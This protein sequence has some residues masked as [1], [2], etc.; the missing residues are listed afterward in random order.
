MIFSTTFDRDWET[1]T[2]SGWRIIQE[3]ALAANTHMNK[4]LRNEISLEL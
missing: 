2:L 1:I 3:S 4:V